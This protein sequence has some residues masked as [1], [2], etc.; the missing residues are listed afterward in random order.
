MAFKFG[1]KEP[2][3]VPQNKKVYRYFSLYQFKQNLKKSVLEKLSRLEWLLQLFLFL[4]SIVF[5]VVY[6]KACLTS[7]MR[8]KAGEKEPL[9]VPQ[10]K[11]VY[12]YFLLCQ[13]YKI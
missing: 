9:E 13:F 12:R 11:K 1:G 5:Q 10:I 4:P 6:L 8:S 3:E 7:T 2:L